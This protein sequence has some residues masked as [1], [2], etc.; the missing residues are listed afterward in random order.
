M[1]ENEVPSFDREGHPEGPEGGIMEGWMFCFWS[2][3]GRVGVAVAV[4]VGAV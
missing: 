3:V 4:A 2:R 1:N